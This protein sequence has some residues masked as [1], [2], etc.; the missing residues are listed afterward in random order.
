MC[1]MKRSNLMA[2]GT[3]FVHRDIEVSFQDQT[4]VLENAGM[5]RVLDLSQSVESGKICA[6]AGAAD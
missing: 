1:V 3:T 4:M 6:A 2:S 5:R